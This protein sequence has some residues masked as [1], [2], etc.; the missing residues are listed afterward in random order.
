MKILQDAIEGYFGGRKAIDKPE[1][2][3]SEDQFTS[4]LTLEAEAYT[5]PRKFPCRD[6]TPAYQA[7]MSRKGRCRIPNVSV[8]KIVR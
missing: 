3:D 2:F 8:V 4:W 6:C 7:E 5:Q 1:C